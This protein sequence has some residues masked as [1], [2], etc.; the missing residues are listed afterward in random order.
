VFKN[1]L[2]TAVEIQK[3]QFVGGALAALLQVAKGAG[4]DLVGKSE[5]DGV[6]EQLDALGA[7]L[8]QLNGKVD[9][10]K[11]IV[12]RS[13]ASQLL[14]QSNDII[15]SIK[16]AQERLAMLARMKPDDPTQSSFA[17]T[18]I[19]HIA[20]YLD[21]AAEKLDRQLRP[22]LAI[23]DNA[24]KATS[25]ALA[26]ERFFD[27]R[28]SDE[29]RS[30][31][32]YFAMYQA[33]L[34]VLLANY[35]NAYPASYSVATR[36]ELLEKVQENVIKVEQESVKPSV[37]VGAFFDTRTPR[38]M[39][40]MDPQTVNVVTLLEKDMKTSTTLSYGGLHNF[41][42]PSS[43]DLVNLVAGASGDPRAWLQAQVNVHLSHQLLWVSD[44]FRRGFKRNVGC[45]AADHHL[46]PAD[47]ENRRLALPQCQRLRAL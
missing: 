11:R 38:F 22:S 8:T 18:I 42:L 2:G 33:Q 28:S 44:P 21:N 4:L 35:Y 40:A 41:Q 20:V 14:A 43:H 30:V 23:G 19:A 34:A 17:Q 3:Q 16:W 37:P 29:V 13:H 7:Q 32:D 15:G 39:W 36:K 26:S 6:R 24:I 10:V 25:R 27:S 5:L 1:L 9:D 31:Y 12:A 45:R 46:R 47:G